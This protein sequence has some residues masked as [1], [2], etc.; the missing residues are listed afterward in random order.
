[1]TE[2]IT[3]WFIGGITIEGTD[4]ENKESIYLCDALDRLCCSLIFE[5]EKEMQNICD[6]IDE[7]KEDDKEIEN[8]SSEWSEMS[9]RKYK[10]TSLD[11]DN[12]ESEKDLNDEW[13]DEYYCNY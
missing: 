3:E 4:L 7:E 5:N 12:Y 1:M 10:D 8:R 6:D 11:C 2:G 13:E 9:Y